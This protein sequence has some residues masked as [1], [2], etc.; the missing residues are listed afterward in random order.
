MWIGFV[1]GHFYI[2]ARLWGKLVFWASVTALFRG[3]LA[4]AGYVARPEP[5]WPDSPSAEA[6]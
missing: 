2:V 1:I 3:R 4:H 6:I 5:T